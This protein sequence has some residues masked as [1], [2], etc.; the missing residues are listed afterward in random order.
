MIPQENHILAGHVFNDTLLAEVLT[1]SVGHIHDIVYLDWVLKGIPARQF[2]LICWN[3]LID[4]FIQNVRYVSSLT[5]DSDLMG[6]SFNDKTLSFVS[7][8]HNQI[9]DFIQ[10]LRISLGF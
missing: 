4:L 3:F 10:D 1:I 7:L 5:D 6:L 8:I 2:S 9:A